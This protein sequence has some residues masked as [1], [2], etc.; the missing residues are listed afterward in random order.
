[1]DKA[2]IEPG[3]DLAADMIARSEKNQPAALRLLQAFQIDDKALPLDKDVKKAA[4][5]G[6][7]S[8]FADGLGAVLI[9][10]ADVLSSDAA[11]LQMMAEMNEAN[12]R[13]ALSYA[14]SGRGGGW[15]E[16]GSGG[17]AYKDLFGD[18]QS[19]NEDDAVLF[20]EAA[21]GDLD[22]IVDGLREIRRDNVAEA[23]AW[24]RPIFDQ[25][26]GERQGK[27]MFDEYVRDMQEDGV[28]INGDGGA[29]LVDP[30]QGAAIAYPDGR[31]YVVPFA[32]AINAA[33][34]SY[35]S[36]ARADEPDPTRSTMIPM[37]TSR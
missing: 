11:S 36:G 3:L 19:I 27:M 31:P 37:G 16:G 23:L 20:A 2:K 25:Q 35:E 26:Y 24:Q 7:R 1:M 29:V 32:E 34:K 6:A 33:R 5:E 14:A 9:A 8:K 13:L 4:E 17:S 15:F 18:Y 30:M 10:Q 21:T 12:R 28:W 22:E